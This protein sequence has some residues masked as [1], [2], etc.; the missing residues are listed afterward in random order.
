MSAAKTAPTSSSLIG[1]T[2]RGLRR[3]ATDRRTI[4]LVGAPPRTA[5]YLVSTWSRGRRT[6]ERDDRVPVRVSAGLAAQVL[7]DEVMM[8]ALKDPALFPRDHDYAAAAH[9]VR[10]AHDL[11]ERQGWLADPVSYHRDPPVPEWEVSTVRRS[12][13]V[14]YEHVCFPSGFAPRTEE[15]ARERW[16]S[17][18]ANDTVHAW[19]LRHRR[20]PRPW[21]VCVHGFGMGWPLAD[22]RGFRVRQLYRAGLNILMPVLPLHGPRAASSVRGQGFMTV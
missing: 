6:D 7:L 2:L 18:E 9:D 15:P 3:V 17:H 22:M 14:R 12:L 20:G 1:D 11:Y 8:A 4:E 21:L 5:A 13:D 10:A 16:L 19:M